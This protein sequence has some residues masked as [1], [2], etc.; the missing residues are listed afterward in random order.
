MFGRSGVEES[1]TWATFERP[2]FRVA[3]SFVLKPHMSKQEV[4]AVKAVCKM[5]PQTNPAA[6]A[7]VSY[8]LIYV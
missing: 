2:A 6:V 8:I 5:I 3:H 7:V 4:D 1:D